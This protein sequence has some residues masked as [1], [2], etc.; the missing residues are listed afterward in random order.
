MS[1]Q[2]AVLQ[3]ERESV[4]IDYS[5]PDYVKI[6]LGTTASGQSTPINSIDDMVPIKPLDELEEEMT[7]SPTSL[8]GHIGNRHFIVGL[9][10]YYGMARY[11][12]EIAAYRGIPLDWVVKKA[13]ENLERDDADIQHDIDSDARVWIRQVRNFTVEHYR[14]IAVQT[15]KYME[16]F[17]LTSIDWIRVEKSLPGAS[18]VQFDLERDSRD[19]KFLR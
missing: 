4:I 18:E 12:V 7:C 1:Q 10:A 9:C 13:Y 8:R 3:S 17:G 14:I 2:E 16:Q 15:L 19:D 11:D 6:P 5:S